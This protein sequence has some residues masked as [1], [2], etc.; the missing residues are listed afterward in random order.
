[1]GRNLAHGFAECDGNVDGGLRS[2]KTSNDFNALLDGNGIHEVGGDDAGRC[3][4]ICWVGGGGSCY[5]G[6]GDRR[7][8]SGENCVRGTDFC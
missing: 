2:L 1:M 5:S 8:I 6:D 7:R 4:R 3:G